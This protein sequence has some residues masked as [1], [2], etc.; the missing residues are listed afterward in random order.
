MLCHSVPIKIKWIELRT[1][2][3]LAGCGSASHTSEFKFT[4]G[5]TASSLEYIILFLQRTRCAFWH[6]RA[7]MVANTFTQVTVYWLNSNSVHQGFASV[8]QLADRTVSTWAI[9]ETREV[10]GSSP[11]W[12]TN[13]GCL[14]QHTYPAAG[15]WFESTPR[16]NPR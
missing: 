11:T 15:Q 10:V 9:R 4:L 5:L 16:G 2:R 3:W 1:N 13:F 12:C 7:V 6:L 8:D 14:Q